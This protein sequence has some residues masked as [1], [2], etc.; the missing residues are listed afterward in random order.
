MNSSRSRKG[1][2]LRRVRARLALGGLSLLLATACGGGGGGGGAGGGGGGGGPTLGRIEGVV[3]VP[4]EDFGMVAEREP[5]GSA[6]QAQRVPPIEP[7]SRLVVAG[8]GGATATHYGAT[9]TVD[10]FRIVAHA[11]QDLDVVLTAMT[12][13]VGAGDFDLAVFDTTTGNVLDAAATL[14]NPEVVS[15][16][17][18][19]DRPAD[20]VVTCASGSGAYTLQFQSRT[21]TSPLLAALTAS[22]PLAMTASLDA[23]DYALATP[24]CVSGRLLV[25]YEGGERGA[26]AERLVPAAIGARETGRT[27]GG[28]RVYALPLLPSA[29]ADAAS[30]VSLA[31]AARLAGEPG[32]RFAEPDAIVRPLA[33]PD[34]PDLG[35]QWH[36]FGID[37]PAAWDTPYGDASVVIGVIDTGIAAHPDLDA[38]RVGG[39]DFVTD[40]P[41]AGDGDGR[42]PDP[43]DP[44]DKALGYGASSWHGTHVAGILAAR[45]NDGYGLCGVAPGCRILALRAA[46]IGGGTASDLSDA[47]RYAAGLAPT[48]HG[49]ALAAPLPIVNVSLGTQTF[50]QELA[51]ACTAAAGAGVLIVSAS[52][53]TGGPVIY[54]AAFPEVLAVGAVDGRFEQ[55]SY[56]N[57]GPELDL[58]APGGS[59]GRDVEGD[60]YLDGIL[61]TSLDETVFPPR[62]GERYEVGTSMASP[63]VAG[64]AG[65]VLSVDPTL[66]A[67]GLR[68]VLLATCVDRGLA[69][70]DSGTGAGLVN[71]GEA[72]RKALA[73]KGTPRVSP[74]RLALST[75]S[76][77]FRG[78]DAVLSVEVY[79]AGGGTLHVGG[80]ANETDSGVPWLSSFTAGAPV[81]AP[82]DV[83]RINV[84]V[85]RTSLADGAYAGT[86]LVTDGAAVLGAI[87][88]LLEVGTPPQT[89]EPF[90]VVA[91][92]IGS[93]IVR[94]TTVAVAQDGYRFALLNV[95]AGTYTVKA[96]T[97][98]DDDSFFCEGNDWCGSYGTEG[99]APPGQV[100]V[101]QGQ[102]VSGLGVGVAR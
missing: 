74:P 1:P 63:A 69:G 23:I 29:S 78:T 81:G 99:G 13:G 92:Q 82:T 47:I 27:S 18:A 25:R 41:I 7:R 97:D 20:V 70:W 31:A 15:F 66:D 46:G 67:A 33:L 85:T 88:V 5:N 42:D 16:L 59:E 71:A 64:V 58:V 4:D 83:S 55:A 45:G 73:D 39:Y 28:S 10:A 50:V 30:R 75:G 100:V 84:L 79:N 72:V 17:L 51:D 80:T 60:G 36:L 68:N 43:T 54:P 56:S 37:A 38:Q 26:L 87:R 53:N 44:G 40:P 35:R 86:V 96:G 11:A 89:G 52:G 49:P 24:D 76:L 90:L 6:A 9:D 19:A 48:A 14:S 8:T 21:P 22:G 98:L 3:L 32:V 95:P 93:G 94:S 101:G 34:D 62:P 2:A 57:M 61:S 77:R 12:G 91:Q 65:L 102:S